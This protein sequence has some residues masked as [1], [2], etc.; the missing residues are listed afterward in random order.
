MLTKEAR[1]QKGITLDELSKDTGLSISLLSKI[2]NG[3]TTMTERA[4]QILDDYYNNDIT[5]TSYTMHLQE[6]NKQLKSEVE[7]YKK[8]I[9][10]LNTK[11]L[12]LKGR[13]VTFKKAMEDFRE[14]LDNDK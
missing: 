13:I 14:W 6:E 1:K 2:E 11:L 5:T 10:L 7:T 3:K 8:E 4:K 12:Y 9:D